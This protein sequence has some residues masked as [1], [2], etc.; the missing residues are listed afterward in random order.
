MDKPTNSDLQKAVLG[1]RKLTVMLIFTVIAACAITYFI[2]A[3]SYESDAVIEQEI[4]PPHEMLNAVLWQKTSAEF[5]AIALQSYGLATNNLVQAV[6]DPHWNAVPE[7]PANAANL[8]PAVIMDLDETVLDNAGY[9]E[10]LIAQNIEFSKDGFTQWCVSQKSTAIPGAV[11]FITQARAQNVAVYF[12]SAR[13][14]A[15]L[16]CTIKSL[17][18]LGVSISAPK[19]EIILTDGADKAQHRREISKFHRVILLI[20]DNLDDFVDGSR[21]SAQQRRQIARQYQEFWGKS[22]IIL[23]NPMYGHWEAAHF[24]HDYGLSREEKLTRKQGA[25]AN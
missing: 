21:A 20:G 10:I 11:D 18:R 23:P 16:E 12:V 8:P 14:A 6:G 15:Q 24:A 25:L 3:R 5:E 13:S 17:N 9:E 19:K 4:R 22:W 1:D 2:T 7:S